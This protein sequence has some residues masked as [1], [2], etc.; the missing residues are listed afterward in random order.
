MDVGVRVSPESGKKE[1]WNSILAKHH[2]INAGQL[3][4]NKTPNHVNTSIAFN[5]YSD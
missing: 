2:I 3:F 5:L 4:P 1:S